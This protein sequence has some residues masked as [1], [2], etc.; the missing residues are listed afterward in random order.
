M[1]DLLAGRRNTGNYQ[2]DIFVNGTPLEKVQDWY[3]ANTG[4][5]L[6][7]GTPYYMELTVRENLTY[8]A[9]MRLPKNLTAQEKLERVE[10]IIQEVVHPPPS[11]PPPLPTPPPLPHVLFIT[12]SLRLRYCWFLVVLSFTHCLFVC[13]C[14]FPVTLCRLA[15][16]LLQLQWWGGVLVLASAVDKRGGFV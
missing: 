5:V 16:L 6:Q 9:T 7:L 4:Y 10:Q 15:S 11:P 1:L 2:G 13:V 3:I 14:V 8:A 12:P